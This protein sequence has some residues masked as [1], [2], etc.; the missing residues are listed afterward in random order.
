MKN[1]ELLKSSSAID[2]ATSKVRAFIDAIVD[3]ESFV[4]TDV[5]LTGKSFD[6]AAEALGEGVV[7]GYA[8]IGGRPV[9]LFAQNSEVL[10]GSLSLAHAAKIVKAMRRAIQSE[11]P[12]LSIIDSC[13]ARVGEGASVME[14][15]AQILAESFRLGREVPHFCV[16]KGTAVGMMATYV[17]GADFAFMSNDAIMSVNAPMYLAAQTKSMPVD[18]KKLIGYS[19]Y[20]QGSD[21]AQFSYSDA[22]DLSAQLRKLMDMVLPNEEDESDDDANRVD[23]QL[24]SA[25]DAA[26]RIASVCDLGQ[27][28]P[29]CDDYASDVRC[30]IAKINGI[31]VGVLATQGD[32]IGEDGLDKA[33]SF[34]GK[35]EAY[36][37]PLVTLV[38]TLGV[39]PTLA[40]E[41]AGIA[42][43]ANAL[44]QAIESAN[45]PKIGVAVGNA[46]GF[47]YTALMSKG[48]GFG[49]TLATSGAIVSP[50]S[51][52]TAV[53]SMMEEQLKKAKDV[54]KMRAT[55]EKEY[56]ALQANPV[57]AAQDGYLDNVVEAT[58]LRPYIASAL[59]M[60][61]GI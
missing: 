47:G 27:V 48:I 37:L 33:T 8:T 59:L 12:F 11:T 22:Q 16:V 29:Y 56:A 50:I 10:K 9:H 15:Y 49:Y 53:N 54:D 58:N 19:A 17:A 35:L 61:L 6:S 5:F 60:L 40:Q 2:K 23:P 21:L 25:K 38:D 32:Y 30:A 14:G 31:T 18:Y 7:T 34:V 28:L 44:M 51:G 52:V 4:E 55:L 3:G 46:V 39:N 45:I 24:E 57:I 36:G 13:G 26:G 1:Q 20:K 43:K 42:K 41:K